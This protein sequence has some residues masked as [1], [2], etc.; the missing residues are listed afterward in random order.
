MDSFGVQSRRLKGRKA[1]ITGAT[2]GIGLAIAE[3]YARHGADLVLTASSMNALPEVEDL[4]RNYGVEVSTYAADFESDD[5]VVSLFSY[6]VSVEPEL[7]ILVNNAGV[8]IGKPFTEH[9]MEDFDRV[10]RINVSSV[11][12]LSQLAVCHMIQLG[13]GKIVNIA[14]LAGLKGSMNSS[15]YNTSKHAIIGLTKCIALE[16]AK[17][18]INVNA[19]CPGIVETDIIRNIEKKVVSAGMSSEE[20][21]TSVEAQSPMGR[22]LQPSEVA[23]IAVFLASSESDGMTGQTI[24]I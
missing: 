7:D 16:T 6:A 18:N 5:D 23:N 1:L 3:E 24:T 14:S 17:K 11:F 9:S 10:M 15:A 20:F 12:H 19:V 8:H 13:R 22:M 2:R 21:W 4:L